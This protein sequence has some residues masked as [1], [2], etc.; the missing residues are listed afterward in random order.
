MATP[1]SS[2]LSGASS[3]SNTGATSM[4][5]LMAKQKA[6]VNAFKKGEHVKG[7]INKLSRSE[8]TV[9]IGGKSEAVVLERDKRI[10][11]R[12]LSLF[13]AGEEVTVQILNPESEFGMPVVS[14]RRYIDDL[15]WEN[16]AA[17]QKKQ[18]TI[19][20]TVVDVTKG[21][22]VVATESGLTGFLPQ[23]HTQYQQAS[24]ITSGTKLAV[25]VLEL[26]RKDNKIIFSQKATMTPEEF[27]VL[28]KKLSIKQKIEVTVSNITTFG[29]FVVVPIPKSDGVALDG[30]IH[31]SEIA[32]DKVADIS[33]LYTV[34]QTLETI[35]LS[36]DKDAKRVDLSIKQLTEDPFAHIVNTYP[37]DKLVKGEVVRTDAAGVWINLG[38]GVEGVIKAEKIPP[39]MTYTIGQTVNATVSEVDSRR[40]RLVLSP[41]LMEK[42]IG[43]R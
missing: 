36:F 17:K 35:I 9:N 34:G 2:K 5:D 12:I 20:V 37:V 25:S 24:T 1:S 8:V 38:D 18:E 30:L 19:D 6:T 16:L 40:H 33:E 15:A 26:Q 41:V 13:T 31:I 4:A 42:P 7:T 11:S 29:L 39:T 32:W 10:L 3:N 14:L 22:F 27:D 21:G 28:T 23:S 43:Y